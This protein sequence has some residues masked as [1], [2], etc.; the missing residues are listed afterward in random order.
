MIISGISV[1]SL[2]VHSRNNGSVDKSRRESR[3]QIFALSGNALDV[4]IM[5]I[6]N[7]AEGNGGNCCSTVEL[8]ANELQSVWMR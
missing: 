8:T 6:A 4:L 3:L 2:R 1:C 7:H 5:L